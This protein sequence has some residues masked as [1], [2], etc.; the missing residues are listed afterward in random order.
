MLKESWNKDIF[1]FKKYSQMVLE[2]ENYRPAK[3][4]LRI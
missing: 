4:R 3:I 2:W 1:P